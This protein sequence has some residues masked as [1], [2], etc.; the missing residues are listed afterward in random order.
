MTGEIC[1]EGSVLKI[2]GVKEKAQGAQQFGVKTLVIP[3]GNKYDF[4]DLPANLKDSFERVFFVENCRQV[5]NIGFNLDTSGIDSYVPEKCLS[6]I[7]DL[8]EEEILVQNNLADQFF[9]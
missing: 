9:K 8:I 4:L 1:I 6:D 2:G 5:Y 3:I 7:N